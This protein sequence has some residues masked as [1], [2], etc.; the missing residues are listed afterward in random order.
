ML[1]VVAIVGRPNVGKSTLFNCLTRSRDALV[2]NEPGLTR[3]RQY[4][5]GK[6]GP[7]PYLVIDTGGLTDDPADISRLTVE[8]TLVA[9]RE[10]DTTLFLVDARQGLTPI[11]QEIASRLRPFGTSVVVVAN[12]ID[13]L[14]QRIVTA[15]FHALGLGDPWPIAAVHGRGVTTM[16]ETV[17]AHFFTKHPSNEKN[18]LTPSG[19]GPIDNQYTEEDHLSGVK[20]AIIGRPNVGKSTLVNRLLGE[21]RVVVHDHPGTTRDSIAVP[22][23]R[24]GKSYVLIDTAGIR[25]KARVSEKIEKFSII[26]SLQA[27]EAA[28]VT[29]MLVDAWEGITDQDAHLIGF[30][31]DT[32]RALAIG[33]NKWDTIE[34]DSRKRVQATLERKL[35]FV[36]FIPIHTI[37]ARFGTRI[38]SL[39]RSVDAASES[40]SR[41]LPTPLLTTI[42]REAVARHPPPLVRG[43]RIK[44]RYAHQ[45]GRNPP[46]IVVHG[47]QT[48]DVSESY[49]RY[50]SGVFREALQLTGTPIRMELRTSENPYKG[51]KNLLTPRQRRKRARLLKHVKK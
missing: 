44:L 48:K 27:I 46:I 26:K 9:L 19:E 36:D 16:M 25:R 30:I 51:R 6:V 47:N 11:D 14:D 32:G 29:I 20:V 38:T 33:V 4:G 45:G 7:M 8:Q 5:V 37:S 40:A 21:E 49:R 39:F 3:D 17:T 50:L 10:T 28:D 2:A 35:P 15:D 1:P 23:T 18:I 31:V 43:R 13:G 12:K 41:A 34:R 22:L 42:L 24:A